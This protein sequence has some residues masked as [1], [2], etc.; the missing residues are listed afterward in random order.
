MVRII[1]FF[2]L[3]SIFSVSYAKEFT[4]DKAVCI[5]IDQSN[6][7]GSCDNRFGSNNGL[8]FEV[9][10]HTKTKKDTSSI[11]KAKK[12][13]IDFKNRAC[14]ISTNQKLWIEETRNF[15]ATTF[16]KLLS[17]PPTV[18]MPS[19]QSICAEE[20]FTFSGVMAT[21]Y[22]TLSWTTSGT[23][24]FNDSTT[25]NPMYTPSSSDISNGSVTL[26]LKVTGSD[27]SVSENC[28]LKIKS[29]P[30]AKIKEL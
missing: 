30:F 16:F 17:S 9:M 15:K 18:T 11:L 24:V 23:G 20:V 6:F 10:F 2:L 12:F 29:K 4:V 21:N 28:I 25:L 26:R 27:G 5:L 22:N 14:F 1:S 19:S 13:D 7:L 8:F 3:L